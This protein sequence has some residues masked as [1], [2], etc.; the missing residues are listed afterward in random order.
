MSDQWMWAESREF[1]IPS[2]EMPSILFWGCES[3]SS[4]YNALLFNRDEGKKSF[5]WFW[6]LSKTIPICHTCRHYGRRCQ[7]VKHFAMVV[8]I[9]DTIW[10]RS[11]TGA[12]CFLYASIPSKD[13]FDA[14]LLYYRLFLMGVRFMM[15]YASKFKFKV[16]LH[17]VQ[18]F[19]D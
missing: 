9:V 6:A 7:S 13:V 11:Q 2:F 1:A 16:P 18:E 17:F 14:I 5:H 8:D 3:P 15:V 19:I 12:F 10:K 4:P